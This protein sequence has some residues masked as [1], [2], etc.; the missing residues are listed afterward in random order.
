[1]IQ[2]NYFWLN[3]VLLAI[4]TITIRLSIIT[5]SARVRISARLRELFSFIPAAILPAFVAPAIFNH[6]GAVSWVLGKERFIV[7]IGA[8]ILSFYTRST[9]LTV[10]CGLVALYLLSSLAI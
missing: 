4:G 1:M 9:F 8:A 7:L 3:V 2:A 6:Q 10:A 5:M